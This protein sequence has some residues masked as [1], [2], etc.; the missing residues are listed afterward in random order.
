MLRSHNFDFDTL[1]RGVLVIGPEGEIIQIGYHINENHLK[2]QKKK[3]DPVVYRLFEEIPPYLYTTN[4]L[5]E[6]LLESYF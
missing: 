2:K 4:K 6:K 1:H 3:D 5:D